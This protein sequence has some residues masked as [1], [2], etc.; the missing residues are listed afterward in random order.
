MK[1]Y[2]CPHCKKIWDYEPF[3]HECPEIPFVELE[4]T[5][6]Q[7]CAKLGHDLRELRKV[8]NAEQYGRS[9][10]VS[11]IESEWV[12]YEGQ[13]AVMK[14]QRCGEESQKYIAKRLNLYN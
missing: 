9:E 8:G 3:S 11:E 6:E 7:L 14:C 10:A 2:Q 4:L 12:Y 1:S 13:W 5:P